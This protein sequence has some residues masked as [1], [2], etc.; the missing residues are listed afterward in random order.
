MRT[1]VRR[2]EGRPPRTATDPEPA[3]WPNEG[4]WPVPPKPIL[5]PHQTP[6]YGRAAWCFA[7]R[8][9]PDLAGMLPRLPRT[10]APHAKWAV[11]AVVALVAAASTLAVT[12]VVS[13]GPPATPFQRYDVNFTTEEDSRF[14]DAGEVEYLTAKSIPVQI[15]DENISAVWFKFEWADASNSPYTDPAISFSISPPR[16]ETPRGTSYGG[17]SYFFEGPTLEREVEVNGVPGN[18]TVVAETP[19]QAVAT[20][21][22]N[23]A[24]ATAGQGEWIFTVDVG[25]A[26]GGRVRPS[27]HITYSLEVGIRYFVAAAAPVP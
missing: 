21:V 24:N 16:Y 8:R 19:E 1:A 5:A 22:E 17:I 3:A 9:M 18:E 25:L 4:P 23:Q 12:A 20:A 7:G 10:L 13:S 26:A 14:T 15:T 27:G 11:P 6:Y 2:I